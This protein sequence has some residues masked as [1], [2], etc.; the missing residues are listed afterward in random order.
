MIRSG[1]ESYLRA[2]GYTSR[3]SEA[4][5]WVIWIVFC[6]LVMSQIRSEAS[7]RCNF[8]W[9][10]VNAHNHHI[11]TAAGPCCCWS[12]QCGF[13]WVKFSQTLQSNLIACYCEKKVQDTATRGV[14]SSLV[15]EFWP[16]ASAYFSD[17]VTSGPECPS[18]TVHHRL[19]RTAI[20]QKLDS[21]IHHS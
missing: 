16:P 6:L 19:S 20:P 5:L 21:Q 15:L 18:D 3:K 12:V 2:L 9:H 11:W 4:K 8:H 14:A 7:I 1:E 17:C 13:Q 10:S